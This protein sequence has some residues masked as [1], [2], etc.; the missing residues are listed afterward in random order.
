MA[1]ANAHAVAALPGADLV[2]ECMVQGPLKWGVIRG[3]NPV[4]G[5]TLKLPD[6]PGLGV[7]LIDDLESTFPYIEGHYSIEVFR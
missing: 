6:A 2:E 7:D 1:M 5:G 3:G 4:S